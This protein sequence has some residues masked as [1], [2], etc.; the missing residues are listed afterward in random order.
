MDYVKVIGKGSY[1]VGGERVTIEGSSPVKIQYWP[2]GPVGEYDPNGDFQAWQ[3]YVQYTRVA[4]PVV[5]Y[6]VCMIHGGGGTGA[7][8]EST[9]D[10]GPGWEFM[11]LQNGFNVNVSD[12]VER[13]RSSWAQFPEINPGPPMFS[14][15]KERWTTYRLGEKL[16]EPY[17]GSRFN[18][19]K[20]DASSRRTS[21]AGRRRCPTRRK[22]TT[23]TS[24]A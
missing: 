12:G 7:L 2:G 10:G 19:D 22:P 4:D 18:A 8:W 23:S 21:P 1:F 16:G 3:M 11:F 6:P 15:Y 14:S 13:G 24:A 5:P 9:Q 17:P 20:Y